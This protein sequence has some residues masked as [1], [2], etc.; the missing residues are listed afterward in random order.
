MKKKSRKKLSCCCYTIGAKTRA[1]QNSE[2]D[3]ARLKSML[4]NIGVDSRTLCAFAHFHRIYHSPF[5][6]TL[7]T[8]TLMN[9]EEM[10]RDSRISHA[11]ATCEHLPTIDHHMLCLQTY[12]G[13]Y[14]TRA[15]HSA[16]KQH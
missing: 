7:Y 13:G 4:P 1:S 11:A 9:G 3:G 8:C 5:T 14:D 6:N 2:A 15:L 10:L 16:A 12:G